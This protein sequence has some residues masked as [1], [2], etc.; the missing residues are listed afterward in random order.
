[1]RQ[2]VL[3]GCGSCLGDPRLFPLRALT[4]APHVV[5][6]WSLAERTATPDPAYEDRSVAPRPAYD[7]PDL[8]ESAYEDEDDEPFSEDGEEQDEG[9]GDAW[10]EGALAPTMVW[11]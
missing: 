8:D 7:D 3:V 4:E 9:E 1:M 11:C 2:S 5:G 6:V 10:S